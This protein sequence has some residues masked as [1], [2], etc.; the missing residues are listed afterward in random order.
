[1]KTETRLSVLVQLAG[2]AAFVWLAIRFVF[3]LRGIQ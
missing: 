1:M 2:F 3:W